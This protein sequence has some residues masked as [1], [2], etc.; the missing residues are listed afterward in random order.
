MCP[1]LTW[2]CFTLA[3]GTKLLGAGVSGKS[4]SWPP[5]TG[6]TGGFNPP[7][8]ALTLL[9]SNS[10]TLSSYNSMSTRWWQKAPAETA[11][12][13]KPSVAGSH[14]QQILHQRLGQGW[15]WSAMRPEWPAKHR[16]LLRKN[17]L[18]TLEIRCGLKCREKEDSELSWSIYTKVQ[19]H[20]SLWGQWGVPG[21]PGN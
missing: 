17:T 2:G 9:S 15:L 16:S 8:P 3:G 19:W 11:P 1:H 10:P 7:L 4:Q 20:L 5:Q 12:E 6:L 21:R 14:L 13:P 18:D